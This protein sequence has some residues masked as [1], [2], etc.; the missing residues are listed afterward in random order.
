[1]NVQTLRQGPDRGLPLHLRRSSFCCCF[2]SYSLRLAASM[3]RLA[4]SAVA[5]RCSARTRASAFAASSAAAA[6][7]LACA[8]HLVY[9]HVH[10][11]LHPYRVTEIATLFIRFAARVS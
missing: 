9:K 4:S 8:P 6:S 2:R 10:V 5:I 11:M 1:M 7:A 3:L